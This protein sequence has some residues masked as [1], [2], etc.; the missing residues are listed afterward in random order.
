MCFM[1]NLSILYLVSLIF[2]TVDKPEYTQIDELLKQQLSTGTDLQK[3]ETSNNS[4]NTKGNDSSDSG[5]SEGITTNPMDFN[6]LGDGHITHSQH[7]SNFIYSDIDDE[8]NLLSLEGNS[9]HKLVTV[10]I[11]I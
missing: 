7:N 4:T 6:S 9:E 2:F 1:F 11:N 3:S 8:T 10:I 5:D